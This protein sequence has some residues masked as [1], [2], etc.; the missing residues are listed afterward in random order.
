[1]SILITGGTGF[2]GSYLARKLIKEGVNDIVLFDAFPNM[3]NIDDIASQVKVIQG[4]FCEPSELLEVIKSNNVTDIFHLAYLLMESEKFVSRAMRVN[5][6]GTSDLFE[7]SR[8]A[9]VRRVIWASSGAVYG[10][11]PET[12]SE[13]DEPFSEESP[14]SPDSM[15]GAS[16]LFNESTAETYTK[17]RGLDHIGFR[18]GS[19][20]GLGRGSRASTVPDVYSSLIENSFFG[21]ECL[22]PPAEQHYPW[23]YVKDVANAFYTA[24]RFQGKPPVRIFN[25]CGESRTIGEV[26][27]YLKSILPKTDIKFGTK[28]VGRLAVCK[29]DRIEKILGF[30]AEYTMEKGVDDYIKELKARKG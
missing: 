28:P 11:F 2:L 21:K 8:I 3:S 6:L 18:L 10:H 27:D 14:K 20:Y 19:I 26:A 12:F 30:K 25:V 16:K 29:A 23:T 5:C 24:Y 22:A 7:V 15:Y 17:R 4:D 1:M 13:D 9:G